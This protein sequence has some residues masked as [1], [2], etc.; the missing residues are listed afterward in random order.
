MKELKDL[1]NHEQMDGR[2]NQIKRTII[3]DPK[4]QRYLQKNKI[5][6]TEEKL[7]NSLSE[8]LVFYDHYF[9]C[10]NCETLEKCKQDTPGYRPELKDAG[11]RLL[12]V[13]KPCPSRLEW[14]KKQSVS[15]KIRSFYLPKSILQASI[16]SLELATDE[17]SE[18]RNQ[19]INYV[20]SFASVYD[21]KTFRRGAYLYGPFGVGKTYIL[22]AMANELA[23][24]GIEV[25]FVYLP[26]L[27]R[28]LKS[29]IGNKSLESKL[30]EIK[31]I[32][33]LVL[34]DIGAEMMTMWVR[35]EIIG[36]ILQHRLLEELP[37]FFTS[38]RSIDELIEAYS[39]TTDGT[40]DK[41]KANR[42]GDRVKAL[43]KEI[44]VGGKNYRY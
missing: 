27:I 11:D 37:T 42:I 26:D 15:S 9:K 20:F 22:A 36:P 25:G 39:R 19:A 18:G 32:Q 28:E 10:E 43:S 24:K 38:N 41:L 16:S 17:K 23:K 5:N 4:V 2:I 29:A 1:L 8:I 44:Y 40:I 30:D 34:D 33:V 31:N 7:A 21:G 13:Y 14:E 6:L 35:D 12:L 3:A